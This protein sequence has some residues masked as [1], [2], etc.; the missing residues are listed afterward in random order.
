MPLLVGGVSRR[1]GLQVGDLFEGRAGG[2]H[3]QAARNQ[4]VARVAIG[5]LL[6]LSSLGHVRDV[7]LEEHLHGSSNPP[8]L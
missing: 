8:T 1:D 5:D 7:L 4:E 2:G 6:E 3:R